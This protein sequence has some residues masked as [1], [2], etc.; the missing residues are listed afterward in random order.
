MF[1]IE[2]TDDDDDDDGIASALVAL[3]HRNS[4]IEQ[5]S[6]AFFLHCEEVMD[7]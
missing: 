2:D 4:T 3:E 7:D 6:L 1:M 5:I